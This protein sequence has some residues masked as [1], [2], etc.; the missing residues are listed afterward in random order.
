MPQ[1]TKHGVFLD[2]L[3]TG[4][5]KVYVDVRASGVRLPAKLLTER[6]VV[7]EY[8]YNLPVPIQGLEAD[9]FG[10]RA[11]LSFGREPHSTFLPWSA[12]QAMCDRGGYGVAWEMGDEN[13][14][15]ATWGSA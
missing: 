10:I 7:L 9:E 13:P 4:L 11:T 8:G 14:L 15:R 12:V 2:L 1:V 6:V 5:V 3:R